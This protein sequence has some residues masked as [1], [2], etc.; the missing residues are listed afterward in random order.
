MKFLKNKLAVTVILLSVAF[1]GIIGFTVSRD[2][3]DILSDGAGSALSPLQ[4]IVYKMNDGL[5]S[6]VDLCLNFSEVKDENKK[7]TKENQEL[8]NKLV[9][10]NSIIAE[11]ERLRETLNFTSNRTN[12]DYLGCNVIGLSGGGFQEGYIIDKGEKDGI[13][14]DM[15]LISEG[16]L[17]GQVTSVGSNYSIVQSILNHNIAVS[18]MI[19]SSKENTG[20]LR[21][22]AT[23]GGDNLTKVTNLSMDSPIKEGDVILTSGVGMVYPKEIRVG[24]VV[25]VETDSVKVMKSAVI[26]PYAE[27]DK[28]QE[29]FVVIPKDTVNI[30]Y[31]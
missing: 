9:E 19:E 27:F 14:K 26:K 25:S 6:F 30:E 16:V 20:I 28:L 23:K 5:K 17:V 7:L 1:L 21:G 11:N 13:K 2:S 12:Y 15:I 10:Y 8:Q 18:V 31:R 4:K 24:E 29:V 22:Y 3:K